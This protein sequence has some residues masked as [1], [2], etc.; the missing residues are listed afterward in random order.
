MGCHCVLTGHVPTRQSQASR[1]VKG[2]KITEPPRIYA[3]TR[4]TANQ[5]TTPAHRL[6][7]F[8]RLQ[9]A[10]LALKRQGLT[11]RAMTGDAGE[12]G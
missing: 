5:L 9:P 3:A 2:S 10:A 11:G 6:T 4:T 1:P 7:E 12:I 8:P